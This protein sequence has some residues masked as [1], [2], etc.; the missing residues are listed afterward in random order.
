MD[1]EIE[2]HGEADL[3]LWASDGDPSNKDGKHMVE[4]TAPLVD[5]KKKKEDKGKSEFYH[6]SPG[7]MQYSKDFPQD[8]TSQRLHTL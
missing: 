3:L 1:L 2:A 5:R 7:N 4:Q 6:P 8:P